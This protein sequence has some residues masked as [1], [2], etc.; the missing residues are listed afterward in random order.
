[1]G[2]NSVDVCLA[3]DMDIMFS[4]VNVHSIEAFDEAQVIQFVGHFAL[5]LGA[6]L[7]CDFS[8]SGTNEKIIDLTKEED[9]AMFR[10]MLEVEAWLMGSVVEA[11]VIDQDTIEVF[12]PQA[13]GFWMSL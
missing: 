5:N 7:F 3:V 1:M 8:C 13:R 9:E 6:D 10:V 11:Q 4:L 2:D 12:M